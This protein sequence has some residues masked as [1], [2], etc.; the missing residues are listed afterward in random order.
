MITFGEWLLQ[1]ERSLVDPH[2]LDTYERAFQQ[3]LEGLI[4]RT[5]DPALQQEF[6]KMR[7]FRFA[8]YIL[9]ALI[10][11]GINQQFDVEDSLQRI[12]FWMLSP[13]GERG[14]PRKSLFDFDESSPY[15]LRVGNPLQAIFRRYLTNAVRTVGM[16]RIPALRRV[17]HPNRLSI[18]YRDPGIDPGYGAVS[19]EEIPSRAA[20]DDCEMLCDIAE[21]L[22]QRSTPGLNLV[23]LFMSIL[24]GEGTRVQRRRFGY[25]L[26]DTGRKQIVRTIQQ[27][28]Q[29]TQNWSLL[30]L[31]DR[32][33]NPEPVTP[34]TRQ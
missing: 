12:V 2:V 11:H 4:R 26:A 18:S 32:I 21:L 16:G 10:R 34:A 5:R 1:E 23:D 8:S 13:V 22:R 17:Q 33:Q 25:T 15:D 19:P 7:T 30:N 14:L 27:Y 9:G 29:Q 31:L 20:N 6:E 24:K 3:Q 28:A